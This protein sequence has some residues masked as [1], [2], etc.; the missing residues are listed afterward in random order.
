M[1]RRV[2]WIAALT[3]AAVLV[4][5]VLVV[6]SLGRGNLR[7][8]ADPPA[9]VREIRQLNELASV[10]YTIQKVIGIRER[11]IPLGSESLLLVV[12]GNVV[13]GIDL[14]Q[15]AP[16]QVRVVK[17]RTVMIDLPGPEIQR[18]Y[19]DEKETQVWDRRV[20]WWTPWVPFSPDLEKQARLQAIE[21]IRTTALEQ[22]I[23]RDANR[24]AERAIE[25]LLKALGFEAV[26]FG[27]S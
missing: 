24:N 1:N 27:V 2:A 15:L 3:A 26:V 21:S 7:Y 12:Q 17:D 11:K 6:L 25:G 5:G 8:R 10:Q 20:T 23:L 14:G 16:D 19:L 13:A 18:V 9:L 22:G 4:V